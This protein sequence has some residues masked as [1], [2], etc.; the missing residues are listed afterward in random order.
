VGAVREA[1]RLTGLVG[2]LVLGFTIVSADL[3]GSVFL[4]AVVVAAPVRVFAAE[5]GLTV[6]DDLTAD[7]DLLAT[8]AAEDAL[9]TAE[10]SAVLCRGLTLALL[11]ESAEALVAAAAVLGAALGSALAA[12]ALGAAAVFVAAVLVAVVVLVA[13]GFTA[14]LV[15]AGFVVVVVVVL[16]VFCAT[17]SVL[18]AGAVSLVAGFSG[19]GFAVGAEADTGSGAGFGSDFG[20]GLGS[21]LGS[22]SVLVTVGSAGDSMPV[23]VSSSTTLSGL[24]LGLSVTAPCCCCCSCW[25]S[26]EARA[27][28]ADMPDMAELRLARKAGDRGDF[29]LLGVLGR[30]RSMSRLGRAD[31][32][33][34]AELPSLTRPM[35]PL[36]STATK[37]VRTLLMSGLGEPLRAS[38]GK[39]SE[40]AFLEPSTAS[41][42]SSSALVSL[43]WLTCH[44]HGGSKCGGGAGRPSKKKASKQAKQADS[45]LTATGAAEQRLG[46]TKTGSL[47]LL[48]GHIVGGWNRSSRDK[49]DGGNHQHTLRAFWLLPPG[50]GDGLET[51]RDLPLSSS[52]GLASPLFSNMARRF[53]TALM[54]KDGSASAEALGERMC[55]RNRC[56]MLAGRPSARVFSGERG[57]ISGWISDIII[58]RLLPA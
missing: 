23:G 11:E 33:R 4:A 36:R 12:A 25:N 7:E 58:I 18:L 24:W 13:V 26:S 38:G 56:W 50:V 39:K 17:F 1:G 41:D 21:G 55:A 53:L 52:A 54:V 2:D 51:P 57:R 34:D 29:S 22:G 37:L 20:S 42:P 27:D 45:G 46:G 14:A 19:S 8:A 28:R 35:T 44:W 9:L 47:R 3:L 31:E 32:S 15:A 6:E 48:V 30:S 10:A 5:V 16:A 40:L 49:A 43:L